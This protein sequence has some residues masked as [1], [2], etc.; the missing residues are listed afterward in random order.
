MF[1][2]LKPL[3]RYMRKVEEHPDMW[4]RLAA[5][6]EM[7]KTRQAVASFIRANVENLLIVSNATT[8][9]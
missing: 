1:F 4:F 9:N 8:G 5:K 7:D 3:Y 2:F 6:T